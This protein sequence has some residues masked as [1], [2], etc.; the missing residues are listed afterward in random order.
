VGKYSAAGYGERAEEFFKKVNKSKKPFYLVVNIADPHKPNFN[1]PGATKRG[2]D[3]HA[4]SRIISESE[5]TIPGFLPELPEIRQDIRNYYNSVK[6]ADDTVGEVMKSLAKSG[7]EKNTLVIFLSDHGMPFPFAKSSVYYHG[8]K[9]PL[10]MKWDGQ[11]KAGTANNTIVSVIDFLPT[12]L[13]L[14]GVEL[15]SSQTYFGSALFNEKAQ[16]L[17]EARSYAFGSFDENASGYPVPMRGVVSKEWNYV[18]NAWSDGKHSIKSAA[19]NH[20]TFRTMVKH[21]ENDADI[22]A[23]V[24]YYTNRATE[25][26]CHIKVD[27]NCL[28][29]LIDDPDYAHIKAE[30]QAAMKQQMIATDDYLLPAF[31]VKDDKKALQKFMNEQHREAKTRAKKYKWKRDFNING[32]TKFNKE[33]Y[34]SAG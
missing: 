24:Q 29:N 32:S 14:A 22:K 19:M 7:L 10:V 33:L 13:D 12:I 1:D 5:V 18:F 8:L 16:K 21:A 31:E 6:R 34:Q 28:V 30:M 2:A 17:L 27:P 15:P 23:R 4:P 26:L 11:I 25:E 9:T 3:V 20:L